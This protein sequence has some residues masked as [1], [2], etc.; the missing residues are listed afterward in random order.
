MQISL[1]LYDDI[2]RNIYKE[3][4][5]R[6]HD[7]IYGEA[8]NIPPLYFKGMDWG[9][10]SKR[11]GKDNWLMVIS[12]LFKIIITKIR[13]FFSIHYY[14]FWASKWCDH[15]DY[16][17][18]LNYQ[19]TL[20]LSL[21]HY[22]RYNFS[23]LKCKRPRKLSGKNWSLQVEHGGQDLCNGQLYK[24]EGSVHE[25][26][27]QG[28]HFRLWGIR[29]YTFTWFCSDKSWIKWDQWFK[30]ELPRGYVLW[31]KYLH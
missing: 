13:Y 25:K 3:Q 16:M 28:F 11:I 27:W 10:I 6:L 12:D 23:Y 18:E 21:F 8:E 9:W 31:F 24:V 30:Q 15:W 1:H 2:E 22:K 4:Q 29:K 14:Q 17:Q 7:D 19:N 20:G 5:V 26:I